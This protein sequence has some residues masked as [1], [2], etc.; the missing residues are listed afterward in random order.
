MQFYYYKHKIIDIYMRDIYESKKNLY[1]T[2]QGSIINNCYA[3]AYDG[4]NVFGLII[5]PRCDL[6]NNAKIST[7]HYLPI[8]RFE[9]WCNIYLKKLCAEKISSEIRK[10]LNTTL[11]ECRIDSSLIDT[12]DKNNLITIIEEHF[13]MPVKKLSGFKVMYNDYLLSLK[14]NNNKD[15]HTKYLNGFISSKMRDLVDNNLHS[16]Y[17]LE[18]WENDKEFFVVL[19]RDVR[20]ITRNIFLKISKELTVGDIN[21]VNILKHNDLVVAGDEEEFVC[22]QAQIKSPFVEHII[23]SFFYN[24]GRVGVDRIDS[25][26]KDRLMQYYK[27]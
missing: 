14:D 7:V 27:L 4:C 19:L 20:R 11:N 2:Q 3:E 21:D 1:L 13:S 24:F 23:Q 22:V 16:C 10:K 25:I 17:L 6:E 18:S 8:V 5:T 26:A 9:D 12:I 15:I